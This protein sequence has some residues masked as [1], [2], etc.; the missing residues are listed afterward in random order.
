MVPK[1][2]FRILVSLLVLAA[3]ARVDAQP[4]VAQFKQVLEAHLQKLRPEGF[5]ARTVLFQSV[6]AGQPKGGYYPF[7][8]TATIHDYGTGYPPNHYYGATCVG[9]IDKWQFDMLKNDMGDWIVQG[10][11][12]VSDNVCKN[13]P[14]PGVSSMPLSG[15]TGEPAPRGQVSGAPSGQAGSAGPSLYIGEFACYG[16]GGRV[17]AGMGF[18]LKSGGKYN[19]LD[20]TRAGTYTFN[21]TAATIAFHGGFLDGQVGRNVHTAGFQLSQTVNC[22][23]WR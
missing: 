21:A 15:L 3:A 4:S 6:R 17:M 19:D 10:R 14:S 16:T 8:V 7:E 18:K 11:M 23:P 9:K 12:T 5:S 22:E 20:G 1:R 2:S 13:N